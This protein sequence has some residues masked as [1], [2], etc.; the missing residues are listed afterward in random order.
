M[1]AAWR[2]PAPPW[3]PANEPW[4]PVRP[5]HEWVRRRSRFMRRAGCLFAVVLVLSAI[6]ATTLVSLIVAR[7]G[8]AAWP[9][10]LSLVAVIVAAAVIFVV[11]A[12]VGGMRRIGFPLGDVV[13]AADRVAAGD[14]SQRV[15][16]RGP[17]PLRS[18][19]RA[20]NSMTTRLER[21]DAQ[22]RK[23]LADIAHELRTPLAVIQGRL[24]GLLDGVYPRDDARLTELLGDT[25]LMARLVEDLGTLANL[26]SGTLGLRKEPTDLAVL[27]QDAVNG[28]ARQA[29][30]QQA[31]LKVAVDPNV[32]LVTIDPVRI[33]EVIANLL[34]NAL[35]HTPAG[36]SINVTAVRRG[37][38][39][40][41]AIADTGSGIL[42]E[43]LPT[44]F[45]R[46]S[47]GAASRGWGLGLTIARDLVAAHGGSIRVDSAPGQGTT[48]TV[49]L[50]L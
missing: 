46:F 13:E 14:F 42:P 47:K 40:D 1:S 12:F 29:E 41:L 38:A 50:P 33:R 37:D 30:A 9:A 44:I 24:E 36:G 48:T 7:T 2:R 49:T 27:V 31:R 20:F 26:E 8:V 43:E 6:G 5:P 39:V 22:R 28:F 4:P 23:L 17:P 18:V 25:R 19:A 3:W 34:S 10:Q 32:P 35:H 16:E 45:D 15:V 21:Q 11:V